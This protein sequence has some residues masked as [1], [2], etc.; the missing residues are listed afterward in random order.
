MIGNDFQS[1]RK[2]RLTHHTHLHQSTTD[3]NTID[4]INSLP[5]SHRPIKKL[6]LAPPSLNHNNL[7][8]CHCMLQII[9]DK[10]KK[11]E[12]KHN[13]IPPTQEHQNHP[14]HPYYK[15]KASDP[16]VI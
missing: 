12:M 8:L 9:L 16:S 10:K 14:L 5:T 2:P 13:D 11:L 7:A 3:I 1:D 15:N 6:E 4:E